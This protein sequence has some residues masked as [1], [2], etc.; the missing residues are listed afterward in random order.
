MRKFLNLKSICIFNVIVVWNWWKII[1]INQRNY[2]SLGFIFLSS[3]RSIVE[4]PAKLRVIRVRV[5]RYS[6]VWVGWNPFWC[7]FWIPCSKNGQ[8]TLRYWI[9]V[10]AVVELRV[11]KAYHFKI[12]I[13]ETQVTKCTRTW[14]LNSLSDPDH[15]AMELYNVLQR[16]QTT[17]QQWA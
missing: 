15:D 11:Q 10:R 5:Y 12:W 14:Y 2:N 7:I 16:T 4:S 3:H 1:N 9:I 17:A 13:I 6:Y 8:T